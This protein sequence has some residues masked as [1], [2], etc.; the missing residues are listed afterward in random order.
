MK[1]EGYRFVYVF[2]E[3]DADRLLTRGHRLVSD[4]GKSEGVY[5]FEAVPISGEAVFDGIGKHA[6][7]N[8]L[9]FQI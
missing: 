3:E 7:S 5:V 6:F 9:T 2:S 4:G 1:N 8:E